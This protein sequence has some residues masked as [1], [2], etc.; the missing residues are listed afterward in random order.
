MNTVSN[1]IMNRTGQRLYC[2]QVVEKE[3]FRAGFD[4]YDGPDPPSFNGTSNLSAATVDVMGVAYSKESYAIA[5][6][7]ALTLLVGIYQVL[8]RPAKCIML[9]DPEAIYWTSS[10]PLAPPYLTCTMWISLSLTTG[11]SYLTLL[12]PS[13][14]L[15]SIQEH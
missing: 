2:P 4:L 10:V 8:N 9:Q 14:S 15:H 13:L 6:A 7:A 1:D 5:I 3:V 11:L 12:F